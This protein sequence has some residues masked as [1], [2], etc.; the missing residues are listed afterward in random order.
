MFLGKKILLGVS[1]SVA[2]YKAA[3]FARLLVKQGAEVQVVMTQSACEFVSPLTFFALT[4]KQAYWQMYSGGPEVATAHIQL[5]READLVVV[6]PASARTI[7]R[8]AHG[9]ADDLLSTVVIATDT[10]TPVVI[11]P[12]MNP[13]MFAHP[14]VVENC[15]KLGTW[16]GYFVAPTGEGEM[17]CGEVGLGRLLEP[18]AL[19]AFCAWALAGGRQDLVGEQLVVTAGPTYEDVDPVRFLSNRSTGKMGFAVARAAASRGAQVTL[20]TSVRDMELPAG[21]R[22]VYVRSA[23]QMHDAVHDHLAGCSMLWK[24][25]AVADYKPAQSATQ[26]LKKQTGELVLSL[27]RTPDIL[28]SLPVDPERLTVGFA[29]ETHDVGQYAQRKLE[30]KRVDMVVANDLTQQGSGFGTQTNEVVCYIPGQEPVQLPMMD[31]LEVAHQLL[32]LAKQLCV[33]KRDAK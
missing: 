8:I 9:L 5:A 6:A 16:P 17:A 24:V 13:Q 7:G 23:Q 1:G 12:A 25:A 3:V 33:R 15:A 30:K 26:K 10:E 32:T 28:G 11:A 18:E 31:K 14:G 22:G 2:A 19:L 27:T 4:G 20:I 29:A 21:C